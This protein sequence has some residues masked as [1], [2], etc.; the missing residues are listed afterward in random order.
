MPDKVKCSQCGFLA[1]RHSQTRQLLD[2]ETVLRE[3]GK[4]PSSIY[5]EHPI[6]FVNMIDFRGSD[7]I[8]LSPNEDKCKE[9]LQSERL[10]EGFVPWMQGFT[11]K[12]HKEMLLTEASLRIQKE[13]AEA[14]REERRRREEADRRWRD[15]QSAKDHAWR[16]AESRWRRHELIVMGGI[17]TLISVVAQIAAAFIERGDLLKPQEPQPT[18]KSTPS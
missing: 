18:A 5:D 2:A 17:V 9:V 7:A 1:A 12:E 14:D 15:D 6:C 13:Q 11:P 8:G 10:C 3:R 16:E 4:L